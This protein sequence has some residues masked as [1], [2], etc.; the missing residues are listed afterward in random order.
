MPKCLD[1]SRP[2]RPF[3]ANVVRYLSC[4][5]PISFRLLPSPD[6]KLAI[7]LNAFS[8]DS[9]FTKP[10]RTHIHLDPPESTERLDCFLFFLEMSTT[11]AHHHYTHRI[12]IPHKEPAMLF[13][14]PD[15][16]PELAMELGGFALDPHYYDS[17]DE[18]DYGDDIILDLGSEDPLELEAERSSPASLVQKL[19]PP[20]NNATNTNTSEDDWK[21]S[22][23]HLLACL[24]LLAVFWRVGARSVGA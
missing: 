13:T 23:T 18:E 21:Q 22:V 2:S 20:N 7:H 19:E 12:H 8:C 9:R 1:S 24:S 5:L 16:E 10:S 11:H 15:P 17:E 4:L 6:S 14:F 3:S